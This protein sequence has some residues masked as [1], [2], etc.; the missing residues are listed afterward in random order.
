MS[1]DVD[2]VPY[3]LTTLRTLVGPPPFSTPNNVLR[4][5][6]YGEQLQ[7]GAG[8]EM[9]VLNLAAQWPQQEGSNVEKNDWQFEFRIFYPFANDAQNGEKQL[10]QVIEPIRQLFRTHLKIGNPTKIAWARPL[11]A[12]WGWSMV[13]DVSY[14]VLSIRATVREKQG[15]SVSA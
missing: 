1:L 5:V 6:K 12:N 8:P 7:V 11:S 15:V 3:L 9:W 2:V 10:A 14:R 4:S 13:N